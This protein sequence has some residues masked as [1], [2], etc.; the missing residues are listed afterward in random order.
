MDS[1][2]IEHAR[3]NASDDRFALGSAQRFNVGG[4]FLW[5][6]FLAWHP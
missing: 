6:L 5:N 3:L 1:S 2:M 4:V